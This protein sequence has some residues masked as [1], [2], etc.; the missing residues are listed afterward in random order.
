MCYVSNAD[1]QDPD[2]PVVFFGVFYF[3]SSF[4]DT[5]GVSTALGSTWAHENNTPDIG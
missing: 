4:T 1:L 5:F 2:W 3:V